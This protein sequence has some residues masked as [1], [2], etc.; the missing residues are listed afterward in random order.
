MTIFTIK[1]SG[2]LNNKVEVVRIGDDQVA[3]NEF[4]ICHSTSIYKDK[5]Y[6]KSIQIEILYGAILESDV[7]DIYRKLGILLEK[8]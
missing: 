1:T 4:I 6:P 8:D 5:I 2:D 3:F 7:K